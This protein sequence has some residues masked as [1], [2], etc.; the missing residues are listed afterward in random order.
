MSEVNS[1][2]KEAKEKLGVATPPPTPQ[3]FALIGKAMNEIGAIGKD[4][5]A[6]NFAGKKMY[7]FRGIDDVYNVINPVFAKYGLFIIPEIVGQTREERSRKN[8][9]G[10]EIGVLIYTILTVRFSIYA[11]DGS[12]VRGTTVGEAMDTGD[13]SANKAMSAALKYF[14]FQTLLIPTEDLRDPDADVYEGVGAR[15]LPSQRKE[16]EPKPAEVKKDPPADV[17]KS[18][19]LP[20]A[21]PNPVLKYIA[22]E[23]A[24]MAG[25]L[26]IA[27]PKEMKAWFAEKRKALIDS[28]AVENI[29][30]IN[31]TMEQAKALV[32]AIYTTFMSDGGSQ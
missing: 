24:F 13:K 18:N 1:A 10:V 23:Q 14:L 11:P 2:I 4:K 19:K 30:A 8:E 7:N 26:G 16:P 22:N 9:S 17:T 28:G 21:K 25:R 32:E 27:D 3:V 31:L 6:K 20:E 15:R 29:P 5:E 12:A